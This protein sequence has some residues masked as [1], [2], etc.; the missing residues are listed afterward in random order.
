M[1][2]VYSINATLHTNRPAGYKPRSWLLRQPYRMLSNHLPWKTREFLITG[3]NVMQIMYSGVWSCM[4]MQYA[5]TSGGSWYMFRTELDSEHWTVQCTFSFELY[6]HV[7]T[8]THNVD[9]L[10]VL[11]SLWH[12]WTVCYMLGTCLLF[13]CL[14]EWSSHQGNSANSHKGYKHQAGNSQ[15]LSQTLVLTSWITQIKKLWFI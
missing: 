2:C 1:D 4:Q 13:V 3:E 11:C 8:H 15:S 9:I 10:R 5:R 7:Q 12:V 6:L 14:F